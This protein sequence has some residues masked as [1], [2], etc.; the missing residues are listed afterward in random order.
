MNFKHS[1]VTQILG[2]EEQNKGEG[3]WK[4]LEQKRGRKE[5]KEIQKGNYGISGQYSKITKIPLFMHQ[6]FTKLSR[7]F[8]TYIRVLCSKFHELWISFELPNYINNSPINSCTENPKPVKGIFSYRL[9]SLGD[10]NHKKI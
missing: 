6:N 1:Q 4:S 8:M 3:N 5:V 10:Q 7:Q 9:A 2:I